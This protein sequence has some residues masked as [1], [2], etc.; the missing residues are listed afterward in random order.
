VNSYSISFRLRRIRTQAARV[1]VPITA[2][3]LLPDDENGSRKLDVEKLVQ[4]AVAL[5]REAST[6]W[7]QDGDDE[8]QLH[9][10]KTPPGLEPNLN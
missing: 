5:G 10:V 4:A 9:P 2:E 1:S 8:I 7:K 6:D 3:V